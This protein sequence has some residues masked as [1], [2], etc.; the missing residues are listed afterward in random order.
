[1]LQPNCVWVIS[2]N[3]LQ[4]CYWN[5]QEF[6]KEKNRVKNKKESLRNKDTKITRVR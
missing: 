2:S 4:F 1:M 5:P 3:H 6:V